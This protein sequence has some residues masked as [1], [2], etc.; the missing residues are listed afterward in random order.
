[1]NADDLVAL[2]ATTQAMRALIEA[3]NAQIVSQG[4]EITALRN[5]NQGFVN[6]LLSMRVALI[7]MQKKVIDTAGST[8]VVSH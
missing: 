3:K 6:E 5:E 1:M 7:D 8:H 4:M 2:D